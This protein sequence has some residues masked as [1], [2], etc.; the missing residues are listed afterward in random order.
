MDKN[1][2]G[3]LKAQQIRQ[4]RDHKLRRKKRQHRADR[5]DN[6]G[7]HTAEKRSA[8]AFPARKPAYITPTAIPSGMLCRVTASTIMVVRSSL[9]FGP[10][11]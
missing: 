8:L 3:F 6:A 1:P 4:R 5:L 11:A 2:R 10:S 9:L 7:K